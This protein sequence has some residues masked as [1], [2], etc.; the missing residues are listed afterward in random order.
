[1]GEALSDWVSATRAQGDPSLYRHADVEMYVLRV[2]DKFKF[3]SI[4]TSHR[5]RR[6]AFSEVWDATNGDTEAIA[7]GFDAAL[8]ARVYSISYVKVCAKNFTEGPPKEKP[9]IQKKLPFQ[10]NPGLQGVLLKPASKIDP[11][12]KNKS[13]RK[14]KAQIPETPTKDT[15]WR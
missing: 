4:G 13:P 6:R 9:V 14:A 12:I 5:D 1:M 8:K 7:Y 3:A 11:P 15:E 10:Q 2:F